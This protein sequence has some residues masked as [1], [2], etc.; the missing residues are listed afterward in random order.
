M[1]VQIQFSFVI[2]RRLC[3][4]F[5]EGGGL[6]YT[7]S[8]HSSKIHQEDSLCSLG[9]QSQVK[10]KSKEEWCSQF[11]LLQ[12]IVLGSLGWYQPSNHKRLTSCSCNTSNKSG[13]GLILHIAESNHSLASLGKMLHYQQVQDERTHQFICLQ[14][15]FHLN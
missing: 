9:H 3:N 15:S 14:V 6:R 4:S 12:V 2:G 13:L 1:I 5:Q 8:S 7:C 11:H 10:R